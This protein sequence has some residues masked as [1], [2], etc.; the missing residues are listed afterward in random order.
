MAIKPG[1]VIVV[2]GELADTASEIVGVVADTDDEGQVAGADD[3]MVPTVTDVNVTSYGLGFAT[4]NDTAP[5]GPPGYRSAGPVAAATVKDRPL[6]AFAVPLPL[7]DAVHAAKAI[8]APTSPTAAMTATM[9][10]TL[11]RDTRASPGSAKPTP[12]GA[13]STTRLRRRQVGSKRPSG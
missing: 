6:N 5:A 10:F 1:M 4:E 7:P 12:H 2:A 8:P 13:A 3:V 11:I 9:T